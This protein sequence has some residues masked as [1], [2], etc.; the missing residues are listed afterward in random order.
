MQ[1]SDIIELN[2]DIDFSP[3]NQEYGFFSVKFKVK[4]MSELIDFIYIINFNVCYKYCGTCNIYDE[5]SNEYECLTC[6][7]DHYMVN[8]IEAD[9][10]RCYS[11]EEKNSLFPNFYFSS[12]T[13][14]YEECYISCSTCSNYGEDECDSCNNDN[15]YY[16]IEDGIN[17]HCYSLE[18]I[19]LIP[20]QKYY[21][22][23]PPSGNIYKKCHCNCF[24]Y[25]LSDINCLS[26]KISF[27]FIEDGIINECSSPPTGNYFRF[28][29]T[30]LLGDQSC[31]SYFSSPNNN[32][33]N[34]K[35][36][37]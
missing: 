16:E 4:L 19:S 18:E 8:S 36:V 21:L 17:N 34:V 32:K 23:S 1:I 37:V 6:K 30:Y 20:E 35:V 9:S 29:D 31:Q 13:H 7:I 33:K 10:R 2:E 25:I 27:F 3:V 22:F 24:E 12:S 15:D 11:E 5:N 14:Q 28:S 26:C